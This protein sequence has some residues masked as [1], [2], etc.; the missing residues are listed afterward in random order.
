MRSDAILVKTAFGLEQ[1]ERPWLDMPWRQRALL[2]AMQ[3]ELTVF[4]LR[5][6]FYD[7]DDVDA[8]LEGL[9]RQGL[10]I[11]TGNQF[12]Q[13]TDEAVFDAEELARALLHAGMAGMR[14][15]GGFVF[16]LSL[17]ATKTREQLLSLLPEFQR[18]LAEGSGERAA[19]AASNRIGM[20]IGDGAMRRHSEAQQR[21]GEGG[22]V[23]DVA[24]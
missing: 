16:G 15:L 20:L 4:E 7:H 8:L 18:L 22:A 24:A 12:A 21:R 9:L 23:K 13:I 6:R 3:G 1:V 17:R 14:R 10:V 5:Q 11:S 19:W 2:V